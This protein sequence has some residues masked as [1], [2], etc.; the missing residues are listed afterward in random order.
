MER[1]RET[2]RQR[3]RGKERERQRQKESEKTLEWWCVTVRWTELRTRIIVL[4]L[5]FQPRSAT[6]ATMLSNT[7]P[8]SVKYRPL[9]LYYWLYKDIIAK[10]KKCLF[11]KESETTHQTS[12]GS[13]INSSRCTR[14]A[15]EK[16]LAIHTATG[17]YF[18]PIT[19]K[20]TLQTWPW[21]YT[22]TLHTTTEHM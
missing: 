12:F 9:V 11:H 2:D 7:P 18:W 5:H 14:W 3:D 22:R 1:E 4:G 8:C 6:S 10:K 21:P 19:D 16:S 13:K 17:I 15:R 20:L